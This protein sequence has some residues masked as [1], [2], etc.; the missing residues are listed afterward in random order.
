MVR[1]HH[2][3]HLIRPAQEGALPRQ[4]SV[5]EFLQNLL[6]SASDDCH[7]QSRDFGEMG[8]HFGREF[9]NTAREEDRLPSLL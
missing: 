2:R 5:L 4:A 9:G 1:S 8:K 7:V 6:P 3:G